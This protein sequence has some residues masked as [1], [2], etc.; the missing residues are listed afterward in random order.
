MQDIADL[1]KIPV[2]TLYRRARDYKWET[3]RRATRRSPIILTEEMYRELSDLNATINER[4]KGQRIPTPTEAETRRKIVYSIAAI[5]KWPTHAEAAFL[6]QSLLRYNEHFHFRGVEGLPE[7][8][9]GFLAHRD[10][11]GYASY[12]PEHNQDINQPTEQEL[13]LLYSEDEKSPYRDPEEMTLDIEQPKFRIIYPDMPGK[14]NGN[15]HA[16]DGARSILKPHVYDAINNPKP[17]VV[18]NSPQK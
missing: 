1:T 9:E 6:F 3:L 14:D 4:P 7:L 2:R 12:Q 8:I 16:A 15:Q 18:L 13:E 11:Y 5:K 10:V 17:L